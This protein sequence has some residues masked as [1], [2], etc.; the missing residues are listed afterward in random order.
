[1]NSFVEMGGIVLISIAIRWIYYWKC[2]IIYLLKV[3]Y[4]LILLTSTFLLRYYIYLCY[5]SLLE[6]DLIELNWS[7]WMK[8]KLSWYLFWPAG[9]PS[10]KE[11]Q[12]NPTA[13]RVGCRFPLCTTMRQT[14]LD[15]VNSSGFVI[16][17][18]PGVLPHQPVDMSRMGKPNVRCR[19]GVFIPSRSVRQCR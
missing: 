5:T 3:S 17:G 15:E 2:R 11:S 19:L 8:L 10:D 6:S 4:R 9:Y 12:K 7:S 18:Y 1:M 16:L 13:N 14:K